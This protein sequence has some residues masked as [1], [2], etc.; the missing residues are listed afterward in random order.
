MNVEKSIKKLICHFWSNNPCARN[1]LKNNEGSK[2]FFK[3]HDELIDK[4][5]PYHESIYEYKKA[6]GKCILEV[7]CGMGS[8]AA[9]FAQY[10][11]KFYAIDLTPKGTKLTKLRFQIFKLF[12][13]I[14]QADAENLPFKDNYFDFVYSN[15]VIHHTPNTSKAIEEIYRVLKPGGKII[16]MI[17]HK[18]SIFYW[19]DL[20][21][22]TQIKYSILK[23]IPTKLVKKI[24]KDNISAL[25][26]K[27]VLNMARWRNLP[28]II[29]R[30]CDG[31][32]NPHTKVYSKEEVKKMF[33]QFKELFIELYSSSD[34]Y[35]D[36][37]PLIN[38]YFGWALFIHA[39]K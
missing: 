7:G 33:F 21:F 15:G 1:L 32:F 35:I 29:L 2:E 4:L 18:N 23:L 13:E 5:T 30:F 27:D 16:V 12:G 14:I 6:E 39:K 10:A 36:K 3:E 37:I 17:Y 34:R 38:K 9:R 8:H 24:F 28:D 19:F 31:H 22:K 25:E 20:M 11:K 26:L